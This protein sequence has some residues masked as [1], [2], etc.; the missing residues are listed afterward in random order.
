MQGAV[1]VPDDLMA[2]QNV[3]TVWYTSIAGLWACE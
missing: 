2:L 3:K 1:G